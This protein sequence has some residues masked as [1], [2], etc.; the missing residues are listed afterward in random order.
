MKESY[1]EKNYRIGTLK[2]TLAQILYH[3]KISNQLLNKSLDDMT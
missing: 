2:K 3:P 1:H